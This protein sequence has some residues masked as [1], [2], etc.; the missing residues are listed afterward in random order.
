MVSGVAVSNLGHQ[1]PEIIRAVKD[2]VDR[3]MHLMVYGELIQSPQV[4]LAEAL[5]GVL[6]PQL[7]STYFVTSGSEA[8]EG[9]L[10]LAKRLPA[11]QK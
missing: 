4:Q 3:Y 11:G 6:P 2:Q 8:I 7:H 10:K 9:A 1:H 5:A